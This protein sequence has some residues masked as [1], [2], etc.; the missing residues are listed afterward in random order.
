METE[1]EE[2]RGKAGDSWQLRRCRRFALLHE[3]WE[4][5]VAEERGAREQGWAKV[6]EF[7]AAAG[8]SI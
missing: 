7:M 8:R 4:E 2:K 1:R 6:G 5:E 3:R